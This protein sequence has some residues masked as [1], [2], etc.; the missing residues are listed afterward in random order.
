MF[1]T[2]LVKELKAVLLS[3]K[4]PATFA[5]CSL[6]IVLSV[7]IG[8]REYRGA[9]ARYAE[10]LELAAQTLR[11]Q[12]TWMNL[13]TT[14]YRK[15]DPMQV[16]VP[17]VDGDVGRLSPITGTED[18]KLT[19]STYADD[20][21]FALFRSIDLAFVVQ[22]VLSLFAILFTYDAINGEREGG[23]LQL[24]FAGAVP[25]TTYILAKIAGA[26]IALAI[27]LI[28]PV[29]LGVLLVVVYGVPLGAGGWARCGLFMLASLFYFTFFVAL[30][31]LVSAL[32]RRPAMSFLAALAAWVVLV[33]I[34]PRIAVM[35]AG[36]VRPVPS[37]AET[38]GWIDAFAKD[39]MDEQM[40]ALGARW[41]ERQA[42]MEGMSA[43]AREA[44]Q[45]SKQQEW[46]NE[47][48]AARQDV[49]KEIDAYR[50]RVNEEQGN[51]VADQE[52]L[53]F[54][55]SRFSPASAYQIAAM[56]LAGTGVSLKAANEAAMREYRRAFTQYTAGKQKE[57]GTQA[58]FRITVDSQTGFHFSAPRE[59]G[60]LDV[61]GVPAFAPPGVKLSEAVS[62]ALV[63][64]GFIAVLALL[65]CAGALVAF[66]RYDVR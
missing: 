33:L 2:V 65:A 28:V 23:T 8:I 16:F 41:Q 20:P 21:L 15:P 49:Q 58:G 17:G 19:N 50:V 66:L 29:L 34:V 42:P 39:R 61:S 63:D 38:E 5:V 44:Y 53:A 22:V 10:G 18:V 3:P 4:F 64:T 25:R 14:A 40:K 13:S 59:R 54:A 30:G 37:I 43:E 47:D 48:D 11:T 9:A 7:F 31:V 62:S 27:P 26:W 56:T 57:S 51:R 1:A 32:T 60:T 46:A 45:Q 35:A 6:L 52:K 36:A 12:S 55:L 24:T